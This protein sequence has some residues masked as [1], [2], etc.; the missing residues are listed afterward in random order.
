MAT[1]AQ[2][3]PS[4]HFGGVERGCIEIASALVAA[5]HRA[6]VVSE[7]GA[8]VADL[9]A[10]GAEHFC[11]PVGQKQLFSVWW[12]ARGLADRLRKEGATV[13]HYRSRAPGWL[14][15][16]ARW[17]LRREGYNLHLVSTYHGVY[18]AAN[19]FKR[20]YNS[21]MVRADRVIAVSRA[22]RTHIE[23]QYP[24]LPTQCVRLIPRGCDVRAFSLWS[25]KPQERA[26]W[27]QSLGLVPEQAILLQVGRLT[28]LKGAAFMAQ[29]LAQLPDMMWQWLL[30]GE[31]IAHPEEV[32]RVQQTLTAA[33]VSERV[34]F[35][36][37]RRDVAEIYPYADVLLSASQQPEAFGRTV[38]ESA[39]CGIPALVP[40]QGGTAEVVVDHKTGWQYRLGDVTDAARKMREILNLSTQARVRIGQ[41]AHRRV[42]ARYRL[43][44]MQR[45]TLDVYAE[46]MHRPNDVGKF[47]D[48][49]EMPR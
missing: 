23:Q 16:L 8:I 29:V 33:G 38:I 18:S 40:D 10:M 41:S 5:G 12:R 7:G 22:V 32:A 30:V 19:A 31:H 42:L 49:E 20:R 2:I 47:V 17:M 11:L 3:L 14:S 13:L 21:V 28:P 15:L 6:L 46:F 35:L 39:A 36:G 25:P 27:A 44:D 34:H 9:S 48:V 4:L 37:V 43:E 26:E 24:Y 1:I 45:A